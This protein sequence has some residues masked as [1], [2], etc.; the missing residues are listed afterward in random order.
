MSTERHLTLFLVKIESVQNATHIIDALFCFSANTLILNK[1]RDNW[2][3]S[4]IDTHDMA[5]GSRGTTQKGSGEMG[6][7]LDIV[8]LHF[9]VQGTAGNFELP[10]GLR[11]VPVCLLKNLVNKGRLCF[12]KRTI[13]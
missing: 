13:S 7:P 11:Q 9:V 4:I 8:F 10:S 12:E 1:N 2:S 3:C 6:R 5:K